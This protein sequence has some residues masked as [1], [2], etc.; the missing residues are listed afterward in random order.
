MTMAAVGLLS[1]LI[2]S[3]VPHIQ[4]QASSYDVV[5]YD[6]TS[7][8]VIAAVA[9]SRHG[10]KTA[11][12]CASW[13]ACFTQ[14]GKRVGGMSSGG[15]G[16][17]DVGSCT[18]IINGI[19]GEFYERNRKH[20]GNDTEVLEETW[21]SHTSAADLKDA[22]A[23]C[24]LPA[25]TCNHTFNLEP[26]VALQIFTEMLEEAN[27]T[28]LYE[29]Q[30]QEVKKTGAHID[31]IVLTDGRMISGSVFIDAGYEGDLF[32][33]A[34]V[35]Y[36]VGR[37][38]N[39]TYN[40]TLN[41]RTI[42]NSG[43]QMGKL[44]DPYDDQGN[45]IPLIFNGTFTWPNGTQEFMGYGA[46]HQADRKVQAY[47]F[48]LCITKNASNMINFTKPD[49]YDPARWELV[50]RNGG[51]SS[52]V[53]CNQGAIP[54]GKYDAN[55]CGGVSTDFI[56]G[57]WGYPEANYTERQQIW[58]EHMDYV[59]GYVWTIMSDP[60][61][62]HPTGW[63]LCADEF[64]DTKGWPPA[65]Y[66]RAARRLKGPKIF[67]QNTPREQ[68]VMGSIGNLSIGMGC[69]NFDSHNAQRI[70]CKTS[71]ACFG[72]HPGK[73]PPTT[74]YV[75]DEGDVQIG[76]GKY[77][78]PLWVTLPDATEA[79]NLLVVAAPSASHIGMSTLR[80]EPQFMIIGHSA[81]VAAALA[82][83]GSGEIAK[84][85]LAELNAQLIADGQ[86]LSSGSGPNPSPPAFTYNC[87]AN[88]C[89]LVQDASWNSTHDSNCNGKCQALQTNEWLAYDPTFTITQTTV[90]AKSKDT[91][92]KKSEL[93]SG[94]GAPGDEMPVKAHQVL[95]LSSPPS[96]IDPDYQLVTLA[97]SS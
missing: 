88:R 82:A 35:S 69:Y 36:I 75:L 3:A 54:N 37:E 14:G 50:R 91:F 70:V 59:Q 26:H 64:P 77:Q 66:V 57:S 97:P 55:N 34:G 61:L 43:N 63:G 90:A 86:T 22:Q 40:E 5:V 79:S 9:A 45:L 46:A 73:T 16:Q 62:A 4:G 96:V 94:S 15:L 20:Y 48:R 83:T 24:R 84:I 60:A 21:G 58:T 92:L 93:H 28:V 32:F 19:A 27:V 1:L 80:M 67:T 53:S 78:I 81:G 44:V 39:T 41:G 47:N 8:G 6:A 29:A 72:S 87:Y 17:S 85:S 65:L 10:A 23:S 31:Q 7:G 56:G 89:M 11:L 71:D 33:R 30:V 74:P 52:G 2:L 49:N 18:E 13:P 12:L 42:K 68:D 95:Q 51:E 38:A 76:P 25:P